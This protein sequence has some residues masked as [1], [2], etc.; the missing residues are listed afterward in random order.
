M[1][2]SK[3]KRFFRPDAK[4]VVFIATTRNYFPD[5]KKKT[6]SY[7]FWYRV[8]KS[9]P[10]CFFFSPQKW[11]KIAKILAVAKIKRQLLK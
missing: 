11:L 9:V 1:Q 8:A 5:Q 6:R 2:S 3:L 10:D 4:I 7:Q